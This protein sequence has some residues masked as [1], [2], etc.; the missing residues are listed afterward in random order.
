MSE[1]VEN[2]VTNY[3]IHDYSAVKIQR[4][5]NFYLCYTSFC[6]SFETQAV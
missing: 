5:D 6:C 3:A 2:P 4:E 1:D